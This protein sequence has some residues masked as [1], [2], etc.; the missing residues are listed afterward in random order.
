MASQLNLS[1]VYDTFKAHRVATLSAL[2]L[3]VAIPFARNDYLTYLSYGPG[4]LPYNVAG[5]LISTIV[6][7]IISREGLSANIYNDRNLPFADEPGFLPNAFPPRRA[8]A[9]PKLGSHP[10]PQRQ[11]EQLPNEHIRQLLIERF[12]A[13]SEQATESGLVEVRQSV[14]ERQHKG[15]FVS[16]SRSW[17]AVAQ[18]TRGEISHVHAGL[19]GSVHVTLSPE[20]CKK[21]IAAGWGQRHGLDGVKVLK[22]LVGFTIPVNY[23]LIYAPRDEAE[24]EIVI[25][26]VKASISFMADSREL[27][28]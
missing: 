5:W 20:D 1:H 21:V 22:K 2:G 9:R 11:L 18:E 23:I 19:D 24:V 12:E 17:H 7:R 13:L 26:I 25:T 3:A 28:E 14:L 8:S 15:I 10:V 16:S 4:G 6:L 27:L